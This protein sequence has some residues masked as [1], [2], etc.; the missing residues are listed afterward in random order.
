MKLITLRWKRC[1]QLGENPECRALDCHRILRV[2]E[3]I[4]HTNNDGGANRINYFCRDCI[5]KKPFII[6]LLRRNTQQPALNP[7]LSMGI[8]PFAIPTAGV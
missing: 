6:Y 1:V 2:G 8:L 5:E 4:Y 3:K 7:T